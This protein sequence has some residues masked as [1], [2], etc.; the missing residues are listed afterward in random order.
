MSFEKEEATTIS[1]H[2]LILRCLAE[3]K[4]LKGEI[5]ELQKK[6]IHSPPPVPSVLLPIIK[7]NMKSHFNPYD[8]ATNGFSIGSLYTGETWIDL[9]LQENRGFSIETNVFNSTT[10]VTAGSYGMYGNIHS[11]PRDPLLPSPYF[12]PFNAYNN[13]FTIG[14]LYNGVEWIPLNWNK[15]LW[16]CEFQPLP[17]PKRI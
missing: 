3:I 7:D 9:S 8:A 1:D 12:D 10:S 14:S 2:D 13:G 6:K 5:I 11:I 4:Q 16:R 17:T 15:H